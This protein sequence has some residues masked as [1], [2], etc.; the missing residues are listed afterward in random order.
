MGGFDAPKQQ[1]IPV[2]YY[3]DTNAH[4][5]MF[6]QDA[7]M[8]A[9]FY[10]MLSHRVS[11]APLLG[12]IDGNVQVKKDLGM[13]EAMGSADIVISR[14]PTRNTATEEANFI[15]R[16]LHKDNIYL[17]KRYD[18]YTIAKE[19]ESIPVP[20]RTN[21]LYWCGLF[22]RRNNPKVNAAF[23]DWFMENVLWSTFDQNSFVKIIH[24][25]EL[26]VATVDWG[27]FY[28]NNYYSLVK[29]RK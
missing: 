1:P 22:L 13:L 14:H 16:E 24:K 25:Y 8:K 27:P 29:H 19:I 2:R 26:K 11:D 5:P 6:N 20:W 18:Y 4:F 9:K 3:D 10:K 21:G 15:L 7:R 23:E 28:D 17:A 12:W